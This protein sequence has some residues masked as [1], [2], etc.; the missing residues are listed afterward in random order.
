MIKKTVTFEDFNGKTVT[1]DYYFNL[2][3]MELIDMDV[4]SPEGFAKKLQNVIDSN[5]GRQI[6][7]TFKEIIL[8]SIGRKSADGKR[9][10][11]S[12]EIREE[13]TQTDAYSE[14]FMELSTD[15]D[16]AAQFVNG[17]IPASLANEVA[18]QSETV[19]LPTAAPE[20]EKKDELSDEELL[21]LDAKDMTPDQLRR[22]FAL[23]SKS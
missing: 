21:A 8:A 11:K 22:A 2:S 9:F 5:D 19:E 15:A 20:L 6:L 18:K 14:L 1:E 12:A 17:I 23:K 7:S 16:A 3:R 4:D 13:F 10:I